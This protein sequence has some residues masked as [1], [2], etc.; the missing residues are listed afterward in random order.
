MRNPRRCSAIAPLAAALLLACSGANDSATVQ[1][2]NQQSALPAA[3]ERV[4]VGET[5]PS[6]SIATFAGDSLI[7][8]SRIPQ[9]TLVNVWATWCVSCKEEFAFMDQLL[10]SYGAGGLR[11]VAVSV[12]VG[13]VAPV[14]R[15]AQQYG[16]TFEVAHDPE[17]RIESAYPAI[18]VPASYLVGRD[19]RLLWKHVGVLPP[20]VAGVIADAL[21]AGE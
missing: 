16:V 12:D 1:S 9:V 20:S 11:I 6:Y 13:A 17:G 15:V 19:G 14:V 5:A 2:R 18:G 3:S 10:A 8:G 21:A 7:L 4:R